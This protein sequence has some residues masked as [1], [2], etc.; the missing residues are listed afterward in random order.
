MPKLSG[1]I[2]FNQAP[3]LTSS[4]LKAI[5]DVCIAAGQLTA[6]SMIFSLI[7]PELDRSKIIVI[8]LGILA[9]IF[10]W[11]TSVLVVRNVKT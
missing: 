2:F 6:G 9:T 1:T 10:A 5:S 8:I 3:I 4:Q 7:F 11:I